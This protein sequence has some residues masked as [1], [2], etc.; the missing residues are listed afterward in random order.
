MI[1][2]KDWEATGGGERLLADTG[3]GPGDGLAGGEGRLLQDHG[4]Q[5]ALGVLIYAPFLILN[6]AAV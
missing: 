3:E 6:P 1:L 5:T 4:Q 2:T